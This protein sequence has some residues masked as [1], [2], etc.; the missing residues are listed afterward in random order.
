MA[1]K[2]RERKMSLRSG[3]M[4][5]FFGYV[6]F[7]VLLF[8]VANPQM[9]YRRDIFA[10][11]P[12]AVA[13]LPEIADGIVVEQLLSSRSDALGDIS[14]VFNTLDRANKGWLI[15]R[16]AQGD[17]I[18][19]EERVAVEE[20]AENTSW[21]RKFLR[22]L[23][24]R[25]D[26]LRLTVSAEETETGRAVALCYNEEG[27]LGGS[28]SV[29]GESVRGSLCMGVSFMREIP[30]YRDYFIFAGV[31]GALILIY[32][33]R[34]ISRE[35][36]GGKSRG[37]LVIRTFERY[38]FLLHQLVS[39][40]FQ[41]KYRRSILGVLWSVL[42]PLLMMIVIS[43]VFSYVFRFKIENFPVYLILGQTLF[44]FFSEATTG[45][46]TTIIFSAGL[47]KKVYIPKY[48]FPVEKVLFSFVNFFISLIAVVIVMLIFRIPFHGTLL[49]L[50]LLLLYLL[51]FTLGI[52]ILLSC[53]AV[54]FRDI[55]H[56]YGVFLAA[57]TYITPI[58][59]PIDSV[60]PV[61]QK[62]LMFNPMTHY[63][64]YF[65]DITMYGVV[66]TLRSNL[67]CLVVGVVSVTVG[68]LV[69]RRKQDKFILH[70]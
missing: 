60:S 20:I 12:E 47:I 26:I 39:R 48:I 22:P 34:L 55:I 8:F 37:L 17:R 28:L 2:N 36:T 59:Y 16:M 27:D 63:V 19:F 5:L 18:L 31:L 4:T 68:L 65:R 43:S 50:P 3:W 64:L 30:F 52:G 7:A 57:W 46:M 24:L 69:F 1:K 14:L 15:I 35:K 38:S 42:N 53:A 45:S 25:G 67:L 44:G 49:F 21:S 58:F 56:I 23:S 33:I 9:K 40:D 6:V 61:M 11:A 62:V 32:G 10:E 66:P 70:I 13:V 54:F 41:L 29:N 51:L